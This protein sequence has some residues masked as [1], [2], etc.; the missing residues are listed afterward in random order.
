MHPRMEEVAG[1]L[2]VRLGR[3]IESRPQ[4]F[5]RLDHVVNRGRRVQSGTLRW[6][7]ILYALAA[8]ARFRRGTLRHAVEVAH[9]DTWLARVHAAVARDYALAVQLLENRRLVKGYS[10][11]HARGLSNFDQVMDAA[12]RL[13]G[14][15]DAADWVRRL[16]EAALRDEEGVALAGAL[17]TVDS[18]LIA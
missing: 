9:R 1:C 15:A 12:T 6:F 17:K 18:F 16:R 10:D 14:R 7:L 13:E 8:M 5:A 11:T 2:P 3:Y 4:L